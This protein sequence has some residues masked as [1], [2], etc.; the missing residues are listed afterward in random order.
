[1]A[2]MERDIFQN[3]IERHNDRE[4]RP[5]ISC[6]ITLKVYLICLKS[7]LLTPNRV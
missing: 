4:E 7:K 6:G 5:L 3:T 2:E 1:M